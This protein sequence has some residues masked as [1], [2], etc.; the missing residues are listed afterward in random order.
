MNNVTGT[1]S[2]TFG[3][4][5][6]KD[7]GYRINSESLIL[8][9]YRNIGMLQGTYNST[10][11]TL[12][13]F[14]INGNK[15]G[16][17]TF[18]KTASGFDGLWAWGEAEPRKNWN[19]TQLS[20]EVPELANAYAEGTYETDY[21][22]L[23]LHQ[24]GNAVF[25]DYKH[26]GIIEGHFNE[27]NKQITGKFTNGKSKGRFV[28]NLTKLGFEG[29]WAWNNDRPSNQ[30][31]G[32]KISWKQPELST[33]TKNDVIRGK[34]QRALL[35]MSMLNVKSKKYRTLYKFLDKAGMSLALQMLNNHYK[36]IATL[37][38][39]KATLSRFTQKLAHLADDPD[40][41]E[42][43]VIMH[44]HGSKRGM[45]FANGVASSEELKDALKALGLKHRLRMF[46]TT[47]CYAGSMLDGIVEGGF[48]CASG[49]R[50]VNTNS[51]TEY[52]EFLLRWKNKQTFSHC[53]TESYNYLDTTILD[54]AAS[55]VMNNV[56]SRKRMK[57]NTTIKIGSTHD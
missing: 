8:G 51:P 14:F 13:G 1:Y 27:N 36:T 53:I 20:T 2:T 45:S 22:Q 29:K 35:V 10:T 56:D 11:K 30:W 37:K 24:Q 49:A 23:R 4:V 52:P 31:N 26:V 38:N 18:K 17:F 16:R 5:K 7:T 32:T 6:L 25:G 33:Y 42:I 40:V 34:N 47:A 21:G 28:F 50:G 12:T 41:R 39:N 9:D 19:G 57:G 3:V 48:T 55:L 54:K 44:C 46:Y 15:K 43:D